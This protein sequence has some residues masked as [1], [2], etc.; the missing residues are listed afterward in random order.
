MTTM[1][2]FTPS[3]L[4]GALAAA[5]FLSVAH[6]Q[7]AP[8]A[9]QTLQ[10]QQRQTPQLPSAGPAVDVQAPAPTAAT[11]GGAQVAINKVRISGATVFTE[12]ELLGVLGEVTGNSYDLAGL[13][14]LADRLTVYYQSRGYP[15]ARALVPQ[16]TI[17]SGELSIQVVEGRY[18]KVQATGKA[19]V[20]EAATGFLI[21]LQSG[22]VIQGPLLE[23]TTLILD[24]QPGVK[25]T[26]LIRPGQAP[27]TGDL[28]VRV[29]RTPG[30]SG[31]LGLD[32]YGNRY[33]GQTRLN[34]SV[35]WDSPFTFGDQLT[36]RG[37]YTD[38]S[39]WLGS[40]GYSLPLG[41]AGLRGNASYAHTTY[42]LGKDFASLGASGTAKVASL[43]ASYPI[44]RSQRT[45]LTLAAAYQRK[46]LNDKQS[47]AGTNND[48]SSDSLPIAL[49]FDR[50][51]AAGG[52]GVTY[53]SFTFTPGH[54]KLDSS[55]AANDA[56]SGLNT[57]GGFT[58]WNLDVARVQATSVLGLTIY[59]RLS[60]QLA[61]SNLDSSEGL[62]LGGANGVRAYPSGEGNGDEGWLA[63][64]EARYAMG[65]FVPYLFYDA[66]STRIN[67]KPALGASENSRSL[68]G[69]G[70]GFRY[71]AGPFSMD[72]T[73][74]WRTK[75]GTSVSDTQNRNPRAWMVAAYRF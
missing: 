29:E 41:A 33:T 40:L 54:L 23:R 19:D 48:K 32:N 60:G 25:I 74:A 4:A 26:P 21:S 10:D 58:K 43:G 36:A 62:S 72:A 55:L 16:Q 11:P 37:M 52:G 53:G 27:G 5:G 20:A 42:E 7:Q 17:A 6:A 73:V 38:E 15:F 47:L 14:T 12:A 35:Q 67:A 30:V 22:Q 63:Q 59:G 9:G 49:N 13:R 57:R 46:E 75:G 28:D 51:D 34:A 68:A 66:G 24:D 56:A 45:N 8:D 71:Q 3:L 44:V 69:A 65:E 39:L 61:N 2:R 70:V 1:T 64:L 31:S 18:G 50:R